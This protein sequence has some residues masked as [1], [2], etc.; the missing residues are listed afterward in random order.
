MRVRSLLTLVVIVVLAAGATYYA[1][2]PPTAL[3][4]TGIITT[5]HIVV[6]PQLGGRLGAVHVQEGDEVHAGQLL[7]SI[8][9]DELLAESAFA[10]RTAENAQWQTRESEADLRYEQVQ[11]VEH[12]R[13]AESTLAATEAEQVAASADLEAARLN[14][15]RVRQLSMEGVAAAQELDRARTSFQAAEARAGALR[16]QADALR[17]AVAL[18]R[19]DA[20]QIAKRQS[21]VKAVEHLAGAALAQR[22]KADVRLAYAD[23]KAPIAGIVDVCAARTGEVVAAGQPIVT[24]VNPDD[25]W[26][27]ADIEESYIDRVRLG[28][29]LTIRLPSGSELDGEVFYRGVDAG[30]ATQRDVSRTK[31]DIKTFEIRLRID[32]RER[33][34]AIGMTAQVLFPLQ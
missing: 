4:L 32:N 8:A 17:A 26:V 9:P 25:L 2:R 5:N 23:I 6:A 28:D 34:L 21:A 20:E 13:Q 11:M 33:R 14:F 10:R 7:A 18:A 29:H 15:D 27:R 3:V 12:I 19:T 24:L 31:R 1:T 22:T 16:K 30:F